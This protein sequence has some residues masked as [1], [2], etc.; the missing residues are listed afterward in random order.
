M[1]L[2]VMKKDEKK[3]TVEGAE[4]RAKLKEVLGNI[5]KNLLIPEPP[6]TGKVRRR[7]LDRLR[8]GDPIW[9]AND[10]NGQPHKSATILVMPAKIVGI[11]K[12]DG[13]F[14]EVKGGDNPMA[15]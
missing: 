5:S 13:T 9:D 11:I 7:A 3:R 10:E 15:T 1:K 2:L 14:E 8:D 4:A 12:E 6:F